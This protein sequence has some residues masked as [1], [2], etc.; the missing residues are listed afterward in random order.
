M[1][2]NGSKAM[3]KIKKNHIS[4]MPHS[5]HSPDISPWN[6][7]LFGMGKEIQRDQEF[8]WSDQIDDAITQVWNNLTFGEVQSMFS[9]CIRHLAW[10]T[11]NDGEYINE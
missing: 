8:S 5:P 4:R 9:D 1:C 3:S 11:G 7:W 2:Q 6:F 10:V